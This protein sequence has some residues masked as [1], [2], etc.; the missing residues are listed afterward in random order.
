MKGL[1]TYLILHRG[2]ET[3]NCAKCKWSR[4]PKR[5]DDKEEPQIGRSFLG[6]MTGTVSS[7][8]MCIAHGGTA[9]V[10]AHNTPSCLSLYEVDAVRDARGSA[11]PPLPLR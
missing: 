10:A 3:P 5:S 9:C 7:N 11:P 1:I 8:M 2:K 4:V 6:I